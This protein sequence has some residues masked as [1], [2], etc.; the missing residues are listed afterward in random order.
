MGMEE[1]N[2]GGA[3]ELVEGLA[4]AGAGE[5]AGAG[6]GAGTTRGSGVTL[7]DEGIGS[8]GPFLGASGRLDVFPESSRMRSEYM[9]LEG[10]EEVVDDGVSCIFAVDIELWKVRL[11]DDPP[12]LR[13]LRLRGARE[14]GWVREAGVVVQG[15]WGDQEGEGC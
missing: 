1:I 3:N 12:S 5:A 13:S 7:A 4:G 2:K 10:F 9:T 11:V 14:G 15:E 6:I 8:V